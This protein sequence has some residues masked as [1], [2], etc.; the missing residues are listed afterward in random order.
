[1][2]P[3]IAGF[4][5]RH[6][7]AS[8]YFFFLEFERVLLYI[9]VSMCIRPKMICMRVPL[10]TLDSCFQG[11]V[12]LAAILVKIRLEL[13]HAMVVEL[14]CSRSRC[15]SKR[16]SA[17]AQQRHCDPKQTNVHIFDVSLQEWL[18]GKEAKK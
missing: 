1:M 10:L 5:W 18:H 12:V 13:C 14:I 9:V 4:D 6:S 8:M 3:L 7:T 15:W 2:L 17:Y 11:A 16:R